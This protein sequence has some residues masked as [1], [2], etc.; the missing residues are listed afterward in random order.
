LNETREVRGTE[1]RVIEERETFGGEL[2]E[3]STNYFAII[4]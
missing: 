3:I 2:V 1:T 4:E